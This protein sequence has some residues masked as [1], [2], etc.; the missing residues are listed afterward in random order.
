MTS[1]S[2]FTDNP[3]IDLLLSLATFSV[4]K[5]ASHIS[6]FTVMVHREFCCSLMHFSPYLGTAPQC[7][8]ELRVFAAVHTMVVSFI[9]FVAEGS[10]THFHKLQR[11]CSRREWHVSHWGWFLCKNQW[12]L[13]SCS[14]SDKIIPINQIARFRNLDQNSMFCL[15]WE[16]QYHTSMS[17]WWHQ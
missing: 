14:E 3:E 16:D 5:N 10:Q 9:Y 17:V 4:Q 11:W 8:C 12:H 13:H 15:L 6:T 7:Q 1:S 2:H